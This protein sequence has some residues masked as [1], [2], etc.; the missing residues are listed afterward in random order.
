MAAFFILGHGMLK[1]LVFSLVFT[2]SPQATSATPVEGT[3]S[4]EEKINEEIEKHDPQKE[5]E[6]ASSDV[7]GV[8]PREKFSL[9]QPTYFIFGKDDLKLQ[10]SGKYRVAKSY[11]LYLGYTQTMFWNIYESSAPFGDINYNPE[12]FYRLTEN[13]TKFLRS[14]DIGMLHTSNGEDGDKSR[15]IN[16]LFAKTNFASHIGRNNILGELKLQH[17]YSKANNNRNIVDYMGYW[18]LKMIVTHILTIGKGRLD[19][20]Y[21]VFAGKKVVNFSSGGRELGLIYHFGSPNFNPSIYFQYFSGYAENLLSYDK[22][23]SNARLGLML[24]F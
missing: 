9:Y 16:R 14:L 18:E 4:N 12:A 22:K 5:I 8:N 13:D 20:E 15:S 19:L 2:L 11:N 17:I 3:T 6:E 7:V 21:R 23:Q 24:F 10:F 1:P